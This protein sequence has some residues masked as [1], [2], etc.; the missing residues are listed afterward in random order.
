MWAYVHTMR[1]MIPY[2]TDEVGEVSRQWMR[3]HGCE[4]LLTKLNET[5]CVQ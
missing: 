1:L 5:K 4:E 3:D 2:F